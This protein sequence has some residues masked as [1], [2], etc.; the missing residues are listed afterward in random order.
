MFGIDMFSR[1]G[2]EILT[3]RWDHFVLLQFQQKLFIWLGVSI[4]FL[5]VSSLYNVGGAGGF[6]LL[7]TTNKLLDVF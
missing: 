4:Y 7:R 6:F 3:L 5:P 1:N 2:G